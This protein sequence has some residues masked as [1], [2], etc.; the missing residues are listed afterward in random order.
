MATHDSS[1]FVTLAVTLFA[2]IAIA[3]ACSWG[4]SD[5]TDPFTDEWAGMPEYPDQEII[6]GEEVLDELAQED[7][8]GNPLKG[9][10]ET[11]GEIVTTVGYVAMIAVSF[12]LPLLAL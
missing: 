3:A 8:F 5:D 6:G 4:V 12:V 9:G 2:C 11:A 10:T 1:T 7:D